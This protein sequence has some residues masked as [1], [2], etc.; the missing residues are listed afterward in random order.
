MSD[1]AAN[2][3]AASTS[4]TVKMPSSP[5]QMAVAAAPAGDDD[6]AVEEPEVI[7]GH[8]SL[9][10]LGD[11]SLSEAMGTAHFALHQVHDMLYWE[12]E[13]IEEEWVSLMEC[14][15]LL[16]KR[17][18]SEKEKMADKQ[19]YLDVMKIMLNRK[20]TTINELDAKAQKLLEDA[21][22]LHVVVEARANAK[23]KVHEDLNAQAI[24]IAHQE[25]AV[26]D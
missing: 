12:R 16:K 17:T 20:Q 25:Q 2:G 24:A 5:P 6:N 23:I 15:S 22:E 19:K 3:P 10:A 21:K 14:G 11:V 26:V 4:P 7:M 13:D 18:T 1:A 9:R 8:P